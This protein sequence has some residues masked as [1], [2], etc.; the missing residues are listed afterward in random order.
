MFRNLCLLALFLILPLPGWSQQQT[1]APFTV[2]VNAAHNV[3]LTWTNSVTAG[4]T[5][6]NVYRSTV[7]GGPYTKINDSPVQSGATNAKD[8]LAG[9]TY[10]YVITAIGSDGVTQSAYSAETSATIP[11]P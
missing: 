5:G 3:V 2:T 10:Y 4:V 1:Q 6:Y 11:S 9:Q 7:S 8:V